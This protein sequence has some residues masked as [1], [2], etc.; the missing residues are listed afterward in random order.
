MSGMSEPPNVDSVLT[1]QDHDPRA[2]ADV[3]TSG[4]IDL[5][6]T[7][8]SQGVI[9]QMSEDKSMG[10]TYYEEVEELK[11]GGMSNADAVR[12]VAKKHGKKDNAV[13]G[14]IHQYRARYIDGGG[15]ATGTVR[16][17][18]HKAEPSVDDFVANARKNMEDALAAVDREPLRLKAEVEELKSELAA[19]EAAY[20]QAVAAAKDKKVELEKKLK[21]LS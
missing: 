19:A 6:I 13:R 5:E 14:G 17:T 8:R 2:F 20:D 11:Q 4:S 3:N 15:T 12:E 9:Y 10:Q 21:A 1:R 16:R 18:R 7:N